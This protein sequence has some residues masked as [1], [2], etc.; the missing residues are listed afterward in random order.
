MRKMLSLIVVLAIANTAFAAPAEPSDQPGSTQITTETM[1]E[2]AGTYGLADGGRV[3]L[4]ILDDQLYADIGRIRVKLQAVSEHVFTTRNHALTIEFNPD[5]PEGGQVRFR[6][7]AD[8][9]A[10]APQ[11]AA[12]EAPET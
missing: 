11:V 10:A 7:D 3:R 9:K 12:D 1:M 6:Y 4:F 8:L 2:V 5:T